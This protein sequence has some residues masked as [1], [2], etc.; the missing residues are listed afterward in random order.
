MEM[1]EL[2]EFT[3]LPFGPSIKFLEFATSEVTNGLFLRGDGSGL[4][5][6]DAGLKEWQGKDIQREREVRMAKSSNV[7]N[8]SWGDGEDMVVVVMVRLVDVVFKEST[9]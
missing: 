8:I 2:G 5:C 4:D 3:I 7:A 9:A 6:V 1:V